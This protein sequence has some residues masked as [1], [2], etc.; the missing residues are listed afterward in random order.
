MTFQSSLSPLTTC[1]I[2]VRPKDKILKDRVVGP[3]YH[4]SCE[5][6]EASYIGETERSLKARFQEHRRPSSSTSEV[7]KHL[8]TEQPG[9]SVQLDKV[10]ILD[11][12]PRWFE[13]GVKE[14]IHI[15]VNKP[16]LNR[17]GGRYQLPSVWD[18]LL[19]K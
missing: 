8:H 17:D 6:C 16:T 5:D 4:I 11:V 10:K 3:V 15:K 9:H 1:V 18:N 7:S 13:R 12:E 19:A 14:A 2:L